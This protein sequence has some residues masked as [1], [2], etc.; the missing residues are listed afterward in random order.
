MLLL[1]VKD[2]DKDRGK[3]WLPFAGC[4]SCRVKAKEERGRPLPGGESW[5]ERDERRRMAGERGTRGKREE[6]EAKEE[7]EEREN[8]V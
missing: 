2:R 6:R 8:T 3:A 1:R 5:S 7:L 4:P